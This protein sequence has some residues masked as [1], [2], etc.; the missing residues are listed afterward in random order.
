M[1]KKLIAAALAIA[2]VLSLSI[3]A[4]AAKGP[5][6]SYSTTAGTSADKG[7]QLNARAR[8]MACLS[9]MTQNRAMILNCKAENT[10]LASQLRTTLQEMKTNGA[11]LSE[12]TLASLNALKTQLQAKRDEL[13]AT[14]GNVEALMVTYRAY[15]QAGDL[16]NAAAILDQVI[17]IQQS[18]ITLETQIKALIQQMLDLL[19]AV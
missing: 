19:S 9:T 11:A 8:I 10:Q 7:A 18:R 3:T 13:A 6:G 2:L 16:E 12:E 14:K 17:A 1:K 15:K 4:S 5:A